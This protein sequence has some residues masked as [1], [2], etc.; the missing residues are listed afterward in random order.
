MLFDRFFRKDK[1]LTNEEK[2]DLISELLVAMVWA[3]GHT[4]RSESDHIIHILA[5]RFQADDAEIMK[6][7]DSFQSIDQKGI[8]KIARRLC[9][10]MPARERVMLLKDL[11]SLAASDGVIDPYEQGLFHRVA[12]LL[13]ISEGVF[14]EKCVKSTV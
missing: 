7:V 5:R 14:M 12:S 9:K 13:H 11:W 8:E 3:D 1:P 6:K 4:D 10:Y 2:Q